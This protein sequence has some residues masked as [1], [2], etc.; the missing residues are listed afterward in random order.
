MPPTK[1]PDHKKKV[2][3]FIDWYLP[4]HKAGGPIRS[5][6]NM[7]RRLSADV[8]F[9][10][11]TSNTDLG[12]IT[13]YPG[14]EVNK[15]INGPGD[16][17]VYYFDTKTPA[18]S[19]LKEILLSEQPDVVYFNSMYSR[20]FMLKPLRLTRQLLPD[21]RVV[22]A[23]RGMLSPGALLIKPFRKRL[24]LIFARSIGWFD[25]IR[26]HAS[27]DVEASEIRNVFGRNARVNVA[28][29]LTIP[30][31]VEPYEKMKRTGSLDLVYV[32]RI[33]PVKNLLQC[34]ETLREIPSDCK[35]NFDIYGHAD[36]AGYLEKCRKMI[37]SMPGHVKVEMKGT[38]PNDELPL[39]FK[40][41]HFT[42]LLTLNEN[43]GH[44]IVESL[45]AGCPVIISDR[46]PWQDLNAADAGWELPLDDTDGIKDALTE[47][48]RM[49]QQ[50]YDAYLNGALA[51]AG[52]IHND[53]HAL[54][55]NRKLFGAE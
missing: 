36:D 19:Q 31:E 42:F 1:D 9:R 5:V 30:T 28:R 48:C 55:M 54:A 40:K 32:A 16:I 34:L 10:I 39:L 22:L 6:Y 37:S 8:D 20:Q 14:I 2:L 25:N 49:D 27:S 51:F 29:N 52:T 53:E 7:V 12:S 3:L 45:S 38:V 41:Y 43:F 13:P 46:T 24:F 47:A 17:P 35:V 23:P 4:G 18:A 26:W 33:S 15:W 11:V 50:Q 21:T 44:A